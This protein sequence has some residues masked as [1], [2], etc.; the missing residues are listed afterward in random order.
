VVNAAAWPLPPARVHGG[1]DH[2]GAV[3]WDFSTNANPLGALPGVAAAVRA[4]ARE[5]YPDPGYRRLRARLAG[6]HA[7]APQQVVPAGSAGEWIWRFTQVLR[8]AGGARRVWLPQPGYAE[9]EA[10]AAALGAAC[11]HYPIGAPEPPA[12]RPGDL[13]WLCEPHS[14]SG[15]TLGPA[16]GPWL[17]QAAACGAE[18][19]LDLAYAP[20][21]LDG[22][23]LPAAAAGAWQLWSPNKACGLTGVRGAYAIAPAGA[24]QAAES[25]RRHAPA[26]VLGADGVAMLEAFCDPAVHRL[27]AAQRPVWA[28]WVQQLG[29]ALQRRHWRV[30]AGVVPFML[31]HPPGAAALAPLWQAAWRQHGLR[32]RDAASFGLPGWARLRALEP[33]AQQ[34]LL[35]AC[36]ALHEVHG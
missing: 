12:L 27:L 26:W 20:L 8:L 35:D 5:H 15:S 14:P 1:P 33:D 28:G 36:D 13:L 9:Y 18:V 31:A 29:R 25:L 34:A 30:R 7:V 11:L 19:A 17:L 3:R 2:R 16:L 6:W 4:A 21:R 10:A 23:A 32:L 22:G 24:A